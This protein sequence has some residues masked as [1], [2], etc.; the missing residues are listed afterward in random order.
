MVT[1]SISASRYNR[2][3][4]PIHPEGENDQAD[5]VGTL[6][7]PHCRNE[8]SVPELAN[9]ESFVCPE[10]GGCIRMPRRLELRP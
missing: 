3:M 2:P 8:V 9:I 4:R 1:P 5:P 7:C 6:T 10:C